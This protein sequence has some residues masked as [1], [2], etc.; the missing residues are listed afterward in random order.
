MPPFFVLLIRNLPINETEAPVQ[1]NDKQINLSHKLSAD[2]IDFFA[3]LSGLDSSHVW[4]FSPN[5]PLSWLLI[6]P[7]P[8]QAGP[9][10]PTGA[11]GLLHLDTNNPG[12]RLCP[13][14]EYLL[15]GQMLSLVIVIQLVIKTI[16][17]RPANSVKMSIWR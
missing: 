1:N 6:S 9:K 13:M 11:S 14:S 7:A 10:G 15:W 8:A 5:V 17:P 16:S 3:C 4:L 2:I 12:L